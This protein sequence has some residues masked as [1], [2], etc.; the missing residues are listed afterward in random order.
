MD[1]LFIGHAYID[2]TFI[3]DQLPSGDDKLLADHYAIAF[4]GNAVTAGFCCAKLGIKPDILCSAA[5]DWLALMF[6]E[7]AHGYGLSIH[8]RKVK[9]SSLSFIMP[10]DG[11]RA[12]VRCRDA[13]YLHPYPQLNLDGCRALHVD[14]HQADA[15]LHYAH[16]C[17]EK[18]ILT[19][20]DGGGVRANTDAVLDHIDVAIMSVRMCD[21]MGLTSEAMLEHLKAKGCRIGGVTEG[22][23]GMLWYDEHGVIHRQPPLAIS[24]DRVVDTN[25][26]GDIF[27][28]AYVYSF[29][30]NPEA[31]WAE[32][33]D[34]ARAASAHAIQHLGNE[35][36]LPSLNDIAR[37]RAEV[38]VQAA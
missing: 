8:E 15:T 38:P 21:Q 1:A 7:M 17:R 10:K 31:G 25:G 13:D 36:S 30:A 33:F 11:K 9:E 22:E 24:P 32:H 18:G 3:A 5:D 14:G 23:R 6:R 16:A 2:V 4:G 26:A 35:A 37:V 34:F 12:I 19:S 20:L 27:H 28:G 29:L